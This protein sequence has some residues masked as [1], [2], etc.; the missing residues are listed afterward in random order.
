MLEGVRCPWCGATAVA[1]YSELQENGATW[2]AKYQCSSITCPGARVSVVHTHLSK[3]VRRMLEQR[4]TEA[5]V[6]DAAARVVALSPHVISL[7]E[8][9]DVIDTVITQYRKA[10]NI[11]ADE[12][13]ERRSFS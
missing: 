4:T 9:L 3:L 7:E 11:L 1:K 5:K 2:C 13:I 12:Q 10:D 6:R 8:K